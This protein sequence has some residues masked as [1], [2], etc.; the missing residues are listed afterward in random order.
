MHTDDEKLMIT[1]HS[2]SL[3]GMHW[4]KCSDVSP[5]PWPWTWP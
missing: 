5:W 2:A 3:P 1:V 4:N